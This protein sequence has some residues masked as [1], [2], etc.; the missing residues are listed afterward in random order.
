MGHWGLGDFAI[1][2][3][4]LWYLPSRFAFCCCIC[5]FICI[6]A[7]ACCIPICIFDA[8]AW[9]LCISDFAFAY[10]AFA[11]CN[12]IWIYHLHS[13]LLFVF[14]VCICILHLQYQFAFA[15]L[16]LYFALAFPCGCILPWRGWRSPPLTLLCMPIPMSHLHLRFAFA[17]CICILP[18]HSAFVFACGPRSGHLLLAHTYIHTDRQI[19]RQAGRQTDRQ[20][21]IHTSALYL[22]KGIGGIRDLGTSQLGD[23]EIPHY[24]A[25]CIMHFILHSGLAFCLLAWRLGSWC[26]VPGASVTGAWPFAFAFLSRVCISPLRVAFA[27]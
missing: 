17:F 1:R 2:I 23:F 10:V 11:F 22:V 4:L 16:Y 7:F 9:C 12:C 19:H 15:L 13:H 27:Y 26:L 6:Y 8:F 21:Y 14:C 5:I 18:S 20:T 3:I 24:F 25:I